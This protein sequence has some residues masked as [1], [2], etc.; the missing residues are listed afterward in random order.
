MLKTRRAAFLATQGFESSELVKP[1]Q[2]LEQAGAKTGLVSPHEESIRGWNE[3]NWGDSV[4][5]DAPLAPEER[6]PR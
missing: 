1:R 2:A 6:A 4:K 5:V 3:P